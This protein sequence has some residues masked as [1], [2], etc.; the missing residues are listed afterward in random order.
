ML[1]LIGVIVVTLCVSPQLILSQTAPA[2]ARQTMLRTAFPNAR[3]LS[4]DYRVG[5]GDILEIQVVN[6]TDLNQTVKVTSAGEINFLSV[7]TIPVQDLTAAEV[8]VKIAS[9]LKERKLVQEP[10]V[11]V[12]IREYQ[13]KR[14]YLVG[15]F[16][17]P[18][19]FVMSQNLTVMDAIL[20]AGGLGA[21]PPSYGFMHRNSSRREVGP[22]P[23][24]AIANP[25]APRAGM[26]IFKIDLTPILEGK[27]P[28]PN[29][30]LKEGDCLIAPTRQLEYFFVLGEVHFPLNYEFPQNQVVRISDAIARAGGPTVV[31]KA[32]KVV[33][34]RV[35]AEGK[36][37]ET[38]VNLEAILLGKQ[39]DVEIRP[40]DIIYIPSTKLGM[41]REQYI[42]Y[43]QI[44]ANSMSF[45]VGRYYQM[46]E[47]G[48]QWWR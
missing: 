6:T 1:R 19:E 7:G 3:G 31:A 5:P 9:A 43:S 24:T 4:Q 41:I 20:L 10:Q 18:G 25:E 26:D 38:K 35:N 13:A 34:S 22:P 23:A 14:I 33:L 42:T 21:N 27:A 15:E 47:E 8:E 45:R 28:E 37:Q 29:L 32:S 17:S 36:R 12:Y 11:L 44:I 2:Q 46:P 16:A 48:R 39:K 30:E 40:N